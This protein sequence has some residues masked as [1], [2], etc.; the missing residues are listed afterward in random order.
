MP[1]LLVLA[2]ECLDRTNCPHPTPIQILK[3]IQHGSRL[4]T[5]GLKLLG[6]VETRLAPHLRRCWTISS[7]SFLLCGWLGILLHH[8]KGDDGGAETFQ[9]A[10]FR[11]LPG[12][13]LTFGEETGKVTSDACLNPCRNEC[14]KKPFPRAVSLLAIRRWV[15]LASVQCDIWRTFR[16]AFV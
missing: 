3:T 1:S 7:I 6:P 2:D 11:R 5:Y 13:R 4:H 14:G 12:K 15:W 9:L 8:Q 16:S 10:F